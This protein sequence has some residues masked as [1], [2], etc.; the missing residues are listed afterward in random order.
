MWLCVVSLVLLSDPG[1]RFRVRVGCV[2]ERG[3]CCR[4]R[5]GSARK[6]SERPFM[7]LVD[8][9]LRFLREGCWM[10]KIRSVCYV[11]MCES[12]GIA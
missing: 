3:F 7:I 10:W 5:V 11:G 8:T 12:R 6:Q 9:L 1:R 4:G 2:G